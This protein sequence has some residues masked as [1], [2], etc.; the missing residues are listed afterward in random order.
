MVMMAIHGE[1]DVAILASTDT[2]QRPVLESFHTLP[3][4]PVPIIEV[5]T[6][7]SPSF[8]KKL[9]VRGLHVWSHYIEQPEFRSLTDRTDYNRA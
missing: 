1:L 5:A 9:Q 4:S 8:S 7:K 6:W 2:D 3:L